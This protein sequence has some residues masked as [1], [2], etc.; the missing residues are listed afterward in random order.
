MADPPLVFAGVALGAA[1][2]RRRAN[3]PAFLGSLGSR[4]RLAL[5][6]TLSGLGLE[7]CAW[8]GSWLTADPSPR[9]LHPQLGPDLLLGAGFYGGMALAFSPVAVWLAVSPATASAVY[10]LW[11][12]LF[13][14]RGAL[15][16]AAARSFS[17]APLATLWVVARVGLVYGAV[18]LLACALAGHRPPAP[19]RPR[20]AWLA[21]PLGLAALT[22]GAYGGTAAVVLAC[23]AAGGLPPPGPIRTRPLW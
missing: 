18:A 5:C 8:L 12:I 19:H 14:Q 3:G 23:R 13:E 20:R 2:L 1:A 21:W 10:G 9:L 17:A 15:L 6:L 7:T 22:V 16:P 11:G 4:S